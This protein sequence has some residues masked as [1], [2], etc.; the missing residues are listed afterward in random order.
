M[1][2]RYP[3]YLP[4]VLLR[5]YSILLRSTD[6]FFTH[7][8]EIATAISDTYIINADVHAIR[9]VWPDVCG[10]PPAGV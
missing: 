4:K 2:H 5:Y 7:T 10:G 1:N 3:Q 8:V 6:T 9:Q